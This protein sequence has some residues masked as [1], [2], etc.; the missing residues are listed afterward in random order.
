[1]V[2]I[3]SFYVKYKVIYQKFNNLIYINKIKKKKEK[4]NIYCL[5]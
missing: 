3:F 2:F 1:M 4:L 5:I